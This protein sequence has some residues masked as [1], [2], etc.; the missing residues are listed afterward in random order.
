[1]GLDMYML[2]FKRVS[3]ETAALLDGKK[4]NEIEE[5]GYM[6]VMD[7]DN[8]ISAFSS[9]LDYGQKIK[10][11]YS[12]V[13]MKKLKKDNGISEDADIV[14]EEYSQNKVTFTFIERDMNSIK[15]VKTTKK[16]YEEAKTGYT[17]M[18]DLK[19][20]LGLPFDAEIISTKP[21]KDNITLTAITNFI[22]KKVVLSDE[23]YLS[24]TFEKPLDCYVFHREEAGYW[25]KDY[26]LQDLIYDMYAE[27]CR[28]SIENLG[29]HK[30]DDEMMREISEYSGEKFDELSDDECYVYHEWY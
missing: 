17:M 18:C 19:E 9:I 14:G 11:V 23:K 15:K 10:A 13:D 25:R 16:E 22:E 20:K 27:K 8:D 7:I 12:L 21:Y 4:A 1:M 29:F 5:M 30:M 24:Y 2:K 26:G 28:E 6:V 3:K